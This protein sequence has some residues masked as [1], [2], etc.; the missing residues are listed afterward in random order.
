MRA[1]KWLSAIGVVAVLI[2][3]LVFFGNFFSKNSSS[4]SNSNS[5]KTTTTATKSSSK[6]GIQITEKNN[7]SSYQ[8]VIKNGRYLTS[9]ARGVSATQQNNTY[10]QVSFENGL[11]DF[12]KEHFSTSKY[13]FQEGQYL[14]TDTANNWLDRKS[15]SNPTGLNP[16]DNGKTDSSRNPIYLQTIEEQDFMTKEGSNLKLNGIVLGLAMNTQDVYQKEQYG[17]S[18]TQ[19]INSADRI[20]KGKEMAN[21]IVQRYRKMNG[22]GNDIPI[23]VA[24]YAQSKDDS[25]A[26]GN[27]YSWNVSKSGNTLGNWTN[28]NDQTVVLPMQTGTGDEKSVA[29]KLNTSFTNFSDNIQSF[30]PNLSFVTG[31]ASYEGNN[32]KGLIIDVSTQFYSATEIESFA[33]YIAQSAPNY[34][35]KGVPVKIKIEASTGMQAYLIQGANDSKYKVT[36]LGSY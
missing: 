18:Y 1:V 20:Q 8:T 11:Q 30:F 2:A 7:N 24:M 14:T 19:D 32:L 21:E 25:L 31:Q 6:K 9:K 34:L 33:N 26:G 17:A 4:V 3:A 16:V 10:D 36:I 27:F 23:Y 35:P 22:I 13:I 28:I 29:T 5:G 15:D 12:A